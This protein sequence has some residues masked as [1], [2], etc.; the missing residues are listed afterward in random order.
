MT[1]ALSYRLALF[2]YI[3]TKGGDAYDCILLIWKSKTKK[4]KGGKRIMISKEQF[5][6]LVSGV[7]P[8]SPP[9]NGPGDFFC[10]VRFVS[11]RRLEMN[12]APVS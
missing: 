1:T 3:L 5:C 10:R 12:C 11:L 7:S 8:S 6:E 9:T 2:S 4:R